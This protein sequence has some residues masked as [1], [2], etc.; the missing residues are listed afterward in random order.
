MRRLALLLLLALP[1]PAEAQ[2][3]HPLGWSPG[4]AVIGTDS[5]CSVTVDVQLFA[6]YVDVNGRVGNYLMTT[7]TSTCGGTVT[8]SQDT[9]IRLFRGG[10]E[11]GSPLGC[12]SATV[13]T[14]YDW[15][16]GSS[17]EV[18]TAAGAGVYRLPAGTSAWVRC[19]DANVPGVVQSGWCSVRSDPKWAALSAYADHL[20]A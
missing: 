13:C 1:L 17:G 2:P 19:V 9:V 16:Y 15:V 20:L 14:R 12:S 3:L 5:A 10:V 6:H 11:V 8:P 4:G 18:V 7:A